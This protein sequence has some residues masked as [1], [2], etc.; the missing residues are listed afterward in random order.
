MK[1]FSQLMGQQS[2]LPIIQ[3]S[4]VDQGVSIAQAM[5]KGGVNIVEVVLR[6]PA[7]LAIISA[8]KSEL[9]DLVVGAGTVTTPDILS[10]ALDAGADFI[11]TP[12]VAPDL[13]KALKSIDVPVLPGVSNNGDIMLAMEAGYT[14]LKLFPANLSGG[15]QYLQSISSVFS[16]LQ[17]CPTGGVIAENFNDYLELG[18]V[19]AAG[20]TWVCQKSWV[21]NNQWE[22][23]TQACAQVCLQRI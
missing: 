5:Q 2:L 12:A 20:G 19:F 13:L 17:F 22:L 7:S 18:N 14:D 15:V 8:I 1:K 23:I 4:S 21:E 3:A 10:D 6:T 11:V 16:S 9:P